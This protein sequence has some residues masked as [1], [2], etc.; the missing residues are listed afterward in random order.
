MAL[1]EHTRANRTVAGFPIAEVIS[2]EDLLALDCD[3]LVPAA[4]HCVLTAKNAA[5]VRA[6][7]VAEG[8]NLPTTPEAD[9][10]LAAREIPVLPDVLSNAG[11]VTV[12]Y[13]EWAQNLQQIFWDEERVNA[14]MRKILTRAYR[15]VA[16]MAASQKVSLRTAAYTL[17]VDR[18]ARAE[19]LRGT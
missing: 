7:I 8:A 14:D 15:Q 2:N 17:A 12:S 11:G 6:R 5:R 18:V 9:E 1:I 4:L 10:I 13:F 3:I 19:R 16:E